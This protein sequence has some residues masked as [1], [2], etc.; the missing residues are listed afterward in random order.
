MLS[1]S[2]KI[3]SIFKFLAV[4]TLGH[5]EYL[6]RLNSFNASGI[7][8]FNWNLHFPFNFW[9]D[10]VFF[11][12]NLTIYIKHTPRYIVIKF[13]DRGL[14]GGGGKL[15]LT[16]M[17]CLGWTCY[18]VNVGGIFIGSLAQIK[19]ERYPEDI[20]HG[21]IW[22]LED[23]EGKRGLCF[24]FFNIHLQYQSRTIHNVIQWLTN[25]HFVGF[26]WSLNLQTLY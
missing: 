4:T 16:L 9:K 25:C 20:V 10:Y 15:N 24:L 11:D 18:G 12:P 22:D 6:L 19:R 23:L 14:V 8:N 13:C 17:K 2:G 3:I 1:F 5:L 21:N 7:N 26:E